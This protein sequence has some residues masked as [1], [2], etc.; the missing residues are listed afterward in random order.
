MAHPAK[1]IF[2]ADYTLLTGDQEPLFFL[3]S[4]TIPMWYW[5][6]SRMTLDDG[7]PWTDPIRISWQSPALLALSPSICTPALTH[8]TVLYVQCSLIATLAP[9]GWLLYL[10][11]ALHGTD[12]SMPCLLPLL[13]LLASVCHIQI[14]QWLFASISAFASFRL[15]LKALSPTY[16]MNHELEGRWGNGQ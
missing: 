8:G 13:C 6:S 12:P 15:R 2:C 5:C 9:A 14:G 11:P 3:L 10:A 16:V 4:S 1:V 7:L